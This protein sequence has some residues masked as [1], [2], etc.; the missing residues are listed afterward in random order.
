MKKLLFIPLALSVV[1]VNGQSLSRK[2]VFA[3]GQQL[4]R[5]STIKMTF[6][7]EMMG[8]SIDMNNNN[9]ITSLV[10]VKNA[11]DKDYAIASTVKRV[12]TSMSGMG[13]EMSYD[14]DKKDGAPNEMGQK[15]AEMVGKTSNITINSKGFITTSDDTTGGGPKAGGFMGMTGGL[16]S[17]SNKPGSSYDLIANLPEKALKVGDTWIDSTVSKEGK[18][19]TNYKVLD[20][21][22]DE[23]TVSMD[24]TVTQ[25]GETE[26]NGMTINLSIQGT[27][28]GTFAMEVATGIIK[29][30]N[31]LLD[32]T[33]TMDVAGQSAPFTMKLNMDEG[34]TKK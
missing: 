27:S 24:G 34:V 28:K 22:G 20:I 33:G 5:V 14:S 26:N 1:F 32:A 11:T 23:A 2:A 10:E 30:R 25:T 31:V 13:Q 7:M 8:Q 21:K 17:A 19:V 6:A 16:T 3:K 29:K 4:E 9:T 18:A 12:V 15:M